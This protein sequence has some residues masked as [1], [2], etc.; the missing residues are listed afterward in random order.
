MLIFPFFSYTK[1]VMDA[2][3]YTSKKTTISRGDCLLT[4]GEP[5]NMS[6]LYSNI[7]GGGGSGSSDVSAVPVPGQ[8]L[9]LLL[10][11][12]VLWFFLT[13]YFDQIFPNEN[14]YCLHPLYFL[15]P[16]YWGYKDPEWMTQKNTQKPL[17]AK[18][19]PPP[20]EDSFVVNERKL[21]T[22]G[23]SKDYGLRIVGLN[24]CYDMGF[25]L[26]ISW[27]CRLFGLDDSFLSEKPDVKCAIHELSLTVNKG[28]LLALLGSNGAGK[29]STMKILYGAS[30][31][32]SG[33]AYIFGR[34]IRTDMNE[35]R[36][37]LGGIA[38]F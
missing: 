17:P 35:I 24:K 2:F 13:L 33:D 6:V 14:G 37:N 30:T 15:F 25:S 3:T 26:V 21:A 22:E 4:D 11:N 16:S 31:P 12:V 18:S 19:L 28:D 23:G 36:K 32:T 7:K 20:N 27:L 10:M 29:T 38:L 9:L 34:N 1:F 8:S 5:F